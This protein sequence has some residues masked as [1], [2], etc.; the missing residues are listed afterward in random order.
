MMMVIAFA[1]AVGV[2]FVGVKT[3]GLIHSVGHSIP[4]A[5][6]TRPA[7]GLDVQPAPHLMISEPTVYRAPSPAPRGH[8]GPAAHSGR[9]DLPIELF[10]HDPSLASASLANGTQSPTR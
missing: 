3:K 7:S 5:P 10:L 2:T 4:D 6:V 9:R 8:A 1:T